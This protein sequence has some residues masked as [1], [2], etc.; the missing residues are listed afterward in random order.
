MVWRGSMA[1]LGFWGEG[2][3]LESVGFVG[4]WVFGWPDGAEVWGLGA[5]CLTRRR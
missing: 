2:W 5:S 1:A 3:G 4:I